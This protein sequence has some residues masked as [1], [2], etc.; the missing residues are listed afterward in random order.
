[1]LCQVVGA[2]DADAVVAARITAT[3]AAI[4]PVTVPLFLDQELVEIT[5]SPTALAATPEAVTVARRYAARR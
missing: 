5:S 2:A 1:V 4:R 3:I